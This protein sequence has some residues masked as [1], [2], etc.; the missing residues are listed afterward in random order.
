LFSYN[1]SREAHFE[2]NIC[3]THETS[4]ACPHF[5]AARLGCH[6]LKADCV[7]ERRGCVLRGKSK[8]AV[9]AEVR[10]RALAEAKEKDAS[11]RHQ[12]KRH[13]A[14]GAR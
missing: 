3:R 10:I 6:L 4:F 11:P 14:H 8:F 2:N 1:A 5:D 12:T 13:G 9:P 7:P